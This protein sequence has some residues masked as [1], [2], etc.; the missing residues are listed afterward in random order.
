MVRAFKKTKSTIDFDTSKRFETQIFYSTYYGNV[1]IILLS[2]RAH[3]NQIPAFTSFIYSL[4]NTSK[5]Y[6]VISFNFSRI[7]LT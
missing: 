3:S 5:D 1:L 6:A 2:L 4:D 7:Y